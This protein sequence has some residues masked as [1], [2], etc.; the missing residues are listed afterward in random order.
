MC[1][2]RMKEALVFA[3][4]D[5]C[6]GELPKSAPRG[7]NAPPPTNAMFKLQ[8]QARDEAKPLQRLPALSYSM[9]NE[10]ALRK[11]MRELGISNTGPRTLLERRHKEWVTI[12]NANCDSARPKKTRELLRDLDSW[13]R[14]Q[15]GQATAFGRATDGPAVK[16]KDFNGD[17]WATKHQASFSD[18]IANARKSKASA[19][20]KPDE[21][22][23]SASTATEPKGP[24]RE[25]AGPVNGASWEETVR[26]FLDSSLSQIPPRL[27]LA[28][29]E[30]TDGMRASQG[31]EKEPYPEQD[32]P[33]WVVFTEQT[34][35]KPQKD[36]GP[37]ERS[38][39]LRYQAG[40]PLDQLGLDELGLDPLAGRAQN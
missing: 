38:V 2:K 35:G 23:A 5:S 25:R 14:T 13:E 18:L 4:L 16:D 3:H 6:P 21:A 12:W 29:Q 37:A 36:W 32:R 34:V 8:S 11:K 19:A 24:I 15:G 20:P 1:H 9:L 31:Q 22:A 30:P 33:P 7:Q 28:G 40:F 39:A 17:A 10:Q 27:D 26:G